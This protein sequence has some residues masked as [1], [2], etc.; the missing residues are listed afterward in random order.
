VVEYQPG[1]VLRRVGSVGEIRW[2][3]PKVL[4]GN[5]L[6]GEWVRVEEASES[7]VLWYGPYRTRQIPL[8]NF[9]NPGLL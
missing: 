4:A 7:V 9:R 1:A 6:A 2:R 3:G 8:A 5:G